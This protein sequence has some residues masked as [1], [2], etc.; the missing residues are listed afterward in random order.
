VGDHED[1]VIE[2]EACRAAQRADDGPLLLPGCP[3]QIVG[4]ERSWQSC[5]PRLRH[6]RTVSVDTPK[7]L[8]STPVGAA[9]RAISARTARVVRALGVGCSAL[10]P[11][12]P[13]EPG[14]AFKAPRVFLNRPTDLIPITFRYQTA[15]SPR[16]PIGIRL[17]QIRDSKQPSSGSAKRPKRPSKRDISVWKGQRSCYNGS[18]SA[19]SCLTSASEVALFV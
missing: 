9:E 5:G 11:P 15:M 16:L 13:R 17:T 2:R 7:R 14:T 19:R 1:E 3:G 8:A 18:F 6:V 12:R 4:A 10:R